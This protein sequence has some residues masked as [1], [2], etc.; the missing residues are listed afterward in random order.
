MCELTTL[1]F[2]FNEKDN[3][4]LLIEKYFKEFPD[5]ILLIVDDDSNDGTVGI[6]KRYIKKFKRLKIIVRKKNRGR[7]YSA[8]F[9]YKY[10]LKYIN[11]PF[12]AHMD[13]DLSHEPE[14]LK[15]MI[16]LLKDY[17]VVIASRFIKNGKDMRKSF[18]RRFL[19]RISNLWV[20]FIFSSQV[21][22]NTS[23]FLV[24]KN[25]VIKT[26]LNRLKSKGPEI[27]EE[28]L[29]YILKENYKILE[30]PY[31]FKERKY[32]K[33]KLNFKKILICF[34]ATLKLKFFDSL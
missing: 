30:C 17:D 31:I 28:V 4:G 21:Y 24:M 29:Y 33:T 13:G 5:E 32:G 16:D 6:V 22:D 25:H 34:Y 20:R 18:F 23:G 15:K 19:S 10:F 26:I 11:T 9:G 27:V 14:I 2:T 1:V 7:G 8:R 12:V 3:I